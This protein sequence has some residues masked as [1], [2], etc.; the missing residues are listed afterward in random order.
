MVQ[1]SCG[2]QIA[3]DDAFNGTAAMCGFCNQMVPVA[4]GA[5][6]A[7]PGYPAQQPYG[8]GG[9]PMGGQYGGAAPAYPGYGGG[10]APQY[11]SSTPPPRG[12]AI[13]AGVLSIVIGALQVIGGL[14]LLL[15]AREFRRG[16]GGDSDI[17][18][19]IGG[20]VLIIGAVSVT[21]GSLAC[22]SKP[23][24]TLTVGILHAVFALLGL[25]GMAGGGVG[26]NIIGVLLSLLTA[27][28]GFAGFGQAKRYQEWKRS[29]GR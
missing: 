28:F 8:Y 25:I 9:Q 6:A 21:A 29:A 22:A 16:F 18:M 17:V 19:I 24:W 27:V 5:A 1:G 7:P 10:Y 11:Q 2:H 26:G 23:G 14:A 12:M 4:S 20:I 3:V 15:L 13:T